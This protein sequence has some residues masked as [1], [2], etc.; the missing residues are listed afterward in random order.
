MSKGSCGVLECG[1]NILARGLCSPHL[2]KLRRWGS[3][4]GAPKR[5]MLDRFMAKVVRVESGCWEWSAAHF[6]ETGYATFCVR[7][8]DGRWRPTVAHR[9]GYELLVGPIAD[10]LELDHL[11]RN[12]GCVN[13]EHLEPVTPRENMRR[14]NSP[15]SIAVRENRCQRGHDFTPREHADQA[16]RQAGV[17]SVCAR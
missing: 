4:D 6:Q 14:S 12:R 13:P 7:S 17:P 5:T 10:G 16:E 8:V 9:V 1:R 2:Q 11:C 15:S 3:V